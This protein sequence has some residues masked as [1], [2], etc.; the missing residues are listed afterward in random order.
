M[1]DT[2][3]YVI[4]IKFIKEIWRNQPSFKVNARH[5]VL[6]WILASR[7]SFICNKWIWLIYVN[8]MKRAI[9]IIIII[10]PVIESIYNNWIVWQAVISLKSFSKRSHYYYNINIHYPLFIPLRSNYLFIICGFLAIQWRWESFMRGMS[11]CRQ[12]SYWII[13][14]VWGLDTP[15]SIPLLS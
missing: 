6:I 8:L 15:D 2:W 11:I 10:F 1:R 12:K 3:A 7:G 5:F 9:I 14:D 13:D 4:R